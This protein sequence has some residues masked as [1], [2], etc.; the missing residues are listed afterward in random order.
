MLC[1]NAGVDFTVASSLLT[2]EEMRAV[3]HGRSGFSFD[4]SRTNALP[5]YVQVSC[6]DGGGLHYGIFQ[7]S[8]SGS[9]F[10]NLLYA[11]TGPNSKRHLC[12]LM[13]AFST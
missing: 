11:H 8:G 2:V 1:S 6:Y 5:E 10:L 3:V 7:Q 9:S 13:L 12:M 4:G